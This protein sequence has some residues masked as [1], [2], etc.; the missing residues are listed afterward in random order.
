MRAVNNSD[1]ANMSA[2]DF[3]EYVKSYES[4]FKVETEVLE[5]WVADDNLLSSGFCVSYGQLLEDRMR[6]C[7]ACSMYYRSLARKSFWFMKPFLI[8]RAIRYEGIHYETL[9]RLIQL[10]TFMKLWLCSR[11]PDNVA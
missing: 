10:K 8:R 7:R 3:R 2:E 5:K 1:M 11:T 6:F 9:G 4:L